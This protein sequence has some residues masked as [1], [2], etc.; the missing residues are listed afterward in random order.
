MTEV[1]VG[2]GANLGHPDAAFADALAALAASADISVRAVSSLWRSAPWGP[3]PQPDY[4]NGAVLLATNRSPRDLLGMLLELE[5]RAG[6]ERRERWGPR[7]LDLDLLFHGDETCVEDDL[8]IPHPR[9]EERSFVLE[10]LVE[11]APAWRHPVSGRTARD[12]RDAL[13][14][15]SGWTPCERI[16]GTR[17]GTRLAESP[18]RS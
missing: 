14:A 10:P 3:I 6:R 5:T 1:A 13:R 12:A 9:M 4:L 17:L 8:R 15:S 7:T 16:A 2:F 11:I 18:C